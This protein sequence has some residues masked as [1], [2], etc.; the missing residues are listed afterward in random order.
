MI[1]F[2]SY[3]R[4]IVVCIHF[5]GPTLFTLFSILFTTIL[6][7]SMC[8]YKRIVF[9]FKRILY[10]AFTVNSNRTIQNH[11]SIC[12]SRQSVSF[13]FLYFLDHSIKHLIFR[14]FIHIKQISIF[15]H[16]FLRFCFRKCM[17]H[18]NCIEPRKT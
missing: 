18:H 12:F 5:N 4:T 7:L 2:T 8:F 1:S 9:M 16:I 13:T 6:R 15:E 3:C 14:K 11:T 17:F 10:H